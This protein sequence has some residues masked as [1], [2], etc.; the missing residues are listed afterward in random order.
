[1]PVP[2]AALPPSARAMLVLMSTMPGSIFDATAAEVAD[3]GDGVVDWL[4][5]FACGELNGNWN[6]AGRLRGSRPGEMRDRRTREGGRDGD[7]EPC[8]HRQ[9]GSAAATRRLRA[10][11]FL[12][13]DRIRVARRK[14]GWLVGERHAG[15]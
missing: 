11:T 2:A 8:H 13:E 9:R 1:M 3:V 5:G 6:A 4:W 15:Q 10:G 14:S 12:A 7:A